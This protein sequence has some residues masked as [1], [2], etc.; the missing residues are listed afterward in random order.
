[1]CL[2]AEA[3]KMQDK[4]KFHKRWTNR[5]QH[6]VHA[7]LSLILVEEEKEIENYLVQT[8]LLEFPE[9]QEELQFLAP[10]LESGMPQT[11][12]FKYLDTACIVNILLAI[13]CC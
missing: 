9:C 2:S 8:N 5:R 7:A 12:N 3:A 4:C 11:Y 13:F 1:M 6:D 10:Q